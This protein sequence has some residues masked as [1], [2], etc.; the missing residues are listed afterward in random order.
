MRKDKNVKTIILNY[1]VNSKGGAFIKFTKS[2]ARLY[3][4]TERLN[5]NCRIGTGLDDGA[6]CNCLWLLKDFDTFEVF[7]K[8]NQPE[9]MSMQD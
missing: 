6:S 3:Q 2:N 9:K 5:K 4:I 8:K 7:R 1:K